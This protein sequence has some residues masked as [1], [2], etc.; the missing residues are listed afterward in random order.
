MLASLIASIVSGELAD[1]ARRA[2]S[3]AVAYLLAAVAAICGVA[4]LIGAAFSATAQAFG[5]V[6][7]ALGFGGGFLFVALLI[8]VI[9]NLSVRSEKKK[10]AQ[11]R[12]HDIRAM[13][14]TAALIIVPAI[15]A[16]GGVGG[17]A[18]PLLAL[19]GYA[20]YRENAPRRRRRR[21]RRPS[22]E[23]NPG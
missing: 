13:A 20:I 8:V 22:D 9:H 5:T 16:R 2:K 12:A 14:Q 7:A 1:A 23:E 6:N 19:L 17:L 4:F 10:A 11:R 3:A 15:I 18:A 21:K